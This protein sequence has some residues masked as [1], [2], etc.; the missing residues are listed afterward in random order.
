MGHSATTPHIPTEGRC[1]P[2]VAP[3]LE[4]VETVVF[5]SDIQHT[6]AD[7]WRR[8]N[9]LFEVVERFGLTRLEI[10]EPDFPVPV[11]DGNRT[12][13]HEC[14]REH[15]DLRVPA[16]LLFSSL[17]VDGLDVFPVRIACG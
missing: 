8:V 14:R 6:F 15:V 10:E 2:Q 1:G 4:R 9:S 7:D 13:S 5:T 16:P 12:A 11:A 3:S 17:R